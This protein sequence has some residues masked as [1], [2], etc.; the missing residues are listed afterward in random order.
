MATWYC[1]YT[2]G[3][4]TTGSGTSGAPWKTLQKTVNSATGGDT[5]NIANTSAQVLAAAI[6][7]N[8]GFTA[9]NTKYTIF[10]AWDNGGSLTIQRPDEATARDAGVI[11]GNNA[12]TF[13]FSITSQPEKIKFLNIRFQ[14]HSLAGNTYMINSG[15]LWSY[16]GCDFD[17]QSRAG[18]YIYM[19]G[20]NRRNFFINNYFHGAVNPPANA[21]HAHYDY[22]ESNWIEATLNNSTRVLVSF[23]AVISNFKSNIVKLTGS[24][25]AV[26][27]GDNAVIIENTFI[28]DGAASQD[29]IYITSG[30][31]NGI[32]NNLFYNV[33]GAS[34]KPL[35]ITATP[36]GALG[37]NAFY[38]CNA[39]TIPS[40][41]VI[42]QNLTANDVSTTGDPFVDSANDDYTLDPT[43]GAAAIG[44]GLG[45]YNS[46]VD[47]GAVQ[48]QSGGG[49]GS[50]TLAS[51]WVG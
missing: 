24:G 46:Y 26:A 43:T 32:Y 34:S 39:N 37:Y 10:Q 13:L 35:N 29:M 36:M 47:I 22:F 17:L 18:Q 23:L 38:D 40:A 7:W 6:T 9:D 19:D 42:S 16:N 45:N 44:A 8:T 2:N 41:T 21:I 4:D 27:S 15:I 30:F 14:N 20:A 33:D 49:G 48:S 28:S 51:A 5:I 31:I 12:T 11:D 50:A 1:D 25:R 3:D